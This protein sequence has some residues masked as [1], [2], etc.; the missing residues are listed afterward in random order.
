MAKVSYETPK[1]SIIYKILIVIFTVALIA[2]I[3]YPKKL[4][5]QEEQRT[6]ECRNNMTH[7]LYAEL[8]YL[9]EKSTYSDSL[10]SVVALIKSDTTGKML[11]TFTNLDSTLAFRIIDDLKTDSLANTIVDTLLRFAHKYNIDTTSALILDSLRTYKDYSQK[12]DSIAL[13]TLDH[14]F[15]CPTVNKPYQISVVD[16]SVIKELYVSCPI[17]SLDSL[18][19]K[20]DFKLHT[21]G[22]LTIQKHGMIENGEKSWE[23]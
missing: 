10:D 22:G 21:L 5:K 14:M 19:V 15:V 13:Y 3:L 11:R 9:N 2:T 17:D 7:I 1:G 6:I 4:W 8:V 18:A 23:K 20:K 12:I 16:T